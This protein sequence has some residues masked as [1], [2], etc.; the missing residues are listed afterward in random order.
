MN[1]ITKLV[2]ES[3]L[4]QGG[5]V[6]RKRVLKSWILIAILCLSTS[7]ASFAGN[8]VESIKINLEN[9]GS[10]KVSYDNQSFDISYQIYNDKMLVGNNT[11]QGFLKLLNVCSRMSGKKYNL[12]LSH[13]IGRDSLDYEVIVTELQRERAQYGKAS[14][15]SP[16][17]F[18]VI[19]KMEFFSDGAARV[20]GRVFSFDD[21]QDAM[22]HVLLIDG[23]YRYLLPIRYVLEQLG[24]N[25]KYENKTV[26][27][28]Y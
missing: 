8:E 2:I 19:K 21:S 18:I 15:Y 1:L 16:N 24:F 23:E 25:L 13:W 12:D 3:P 6:M 27:I 28:T 4:K 9:N 5:Q 10:A 26:M 14:S 20:D 7:T 17:S 22:P 11:D